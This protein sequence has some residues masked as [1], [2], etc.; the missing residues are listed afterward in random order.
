MIVFHVFLYTTGEERRF[1]Q[2]DTE[3]RDG[4]RG[5]LIQELAECSP[6]KLPDCIMAA[7]PPGNCLFTLSTSPVS[8]NGGAAA[9]CA[10]RQ[11]LL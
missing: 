5:S 7:T 10:R 11:L 4:E 9:S 1:T 6:A 2:R 3:A 8:V